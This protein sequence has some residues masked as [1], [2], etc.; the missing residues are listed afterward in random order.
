[1]SVFNDAQEWL[2]TESPLDDE[3]KET[4]NRLSLNCST[5]K[6]PADKEEYRKA[7][8]MLKDNLKTEELFISGSSKRG[9]A[10]FPTS[11]GEEK[12]HEPVSSN[13][14]IKTEGSHAASPIKD[15]T[16]I[17]MIAKFLVKRGYEREAHLL[18]IG[19]NAALRYSDLR[20]I[21]FDQIIHSAKDDG[22]A[23]IEQIVE[24][25][26]SKLKRLVLNKTAMQ[27]IN[28]RHTALLEL[29]HDPIYVFQGT[30][31]RV[32]ANP[33]PIS[34]SHIN[35]VFQYA[36][37]E[38]NLDFRLSSHSLRKSFGFHAYNG[39]KGIDIKVLQKLFNHSSELD[40]FTY[41]GVSAQRVQEAYIDAEIE[42]EL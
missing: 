10:A 34:R 7:I 13:V 36:R 25:K 41:I 38:L 30:G 35:K 23:Y 22:T 32:K 3:I 42:I 40:T 31:N 37:E 6:N 24:K 28:L 5:T 8:S 1:M 15:K 20:M 27:Y 9:V 21:R 18:I 4:I 12:K 33:A 26:T 39:G 17:R 11:N 16:D 14:K 29:G 19:C 2:D